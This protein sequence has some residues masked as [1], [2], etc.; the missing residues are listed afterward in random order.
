MKRVVWAA[1]T[2]VVAGLVA[3]VLYVSVHIARQSERDEARKAD[4]ILVLNQ[5]RIVEQG[6]H[7]KLILQSGFYREIFEQQMTG[8]AKLAVA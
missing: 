1:M 2:A 7:D 6:R 5:G 3:S 8:N 4:L